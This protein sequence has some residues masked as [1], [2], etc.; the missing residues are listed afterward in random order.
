[1]EFFRQYSQQILN[2]NSTKKKEK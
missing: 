1:M 2:L